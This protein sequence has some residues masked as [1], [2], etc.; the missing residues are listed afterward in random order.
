MSEG[1][2]VGQ[3]RCVRATPKALLLKID[4]VGEEWVPRSQIHDDSEVYDEDHNGTLVVLSTLRRV[5]LPHSGQARCC[6]HVDSARLT[7]TPAYSR[8]SLTQRLMSHSPNAK[9]AT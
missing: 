3:A 5:T 1:Y 2:E 7:A 8:T 4:G 6:H 9:T